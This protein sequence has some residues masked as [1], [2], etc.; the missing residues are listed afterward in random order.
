[1]VANELIVKSEADIDWWDEDPVI[2]TTNYLLIR[3]PHVESITLNGAIVG[4]IDGLESKELELTLKGATSITADVEVTF[5]EAYLRGASTL[6]LT[7]EAQEFKTKL[8]GACNL[9]A[10]RFN[11]KTTF[12][13]VTG[14]STAH[15]YGDHF[16]DID[17]AGVST[18]IYGGTDN[19]E[20]QSGHLSN[21]IKK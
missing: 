12:A 15:I 14:A 10:S 13:H 16:L 6:Q 20:I 7:G 21:V 5:L 4:K 11:T 3:T 17:V 19:T 1:M 2:E 8:I 9:D 18:V